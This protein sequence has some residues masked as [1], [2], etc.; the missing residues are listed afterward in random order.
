M[1]KGFLFYD[2]YGIPDSYR[3]IVAFAAPVQPKASGLLKTIQIG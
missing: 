2:I 3:G 1:M